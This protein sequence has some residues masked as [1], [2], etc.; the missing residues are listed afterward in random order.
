M[1]RRQRQKRR[2]QRNGGFRKGF[3]IALSVGIVAGFVG[4]LGLVGY[5]IGVAASAPSIDSLKPIDHGQTSVVYAADGKRLGFIT[6]DEL[7]TPVQ[8]TVIPNALKEATIAIEDQRFYHHKGVDYQAVIR[9]IHTDLRAGHYVQGAST[10]TQQL[11]RN[12]YTGSERTLGR[13]AKEALLAVQAERVY[14]KEEILARYLN[15]VYLGESTF[16]VEAASQSYFRKP[17]KELTLAEAAL[18]AGVIPAP[19]VYSP[20]ANPELA[21]KLQELEAKYAEHDKQLVVVFEAIG[22]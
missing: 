8:T 14:S 15:T 18:L 20:R 9:A 10:I 2:K 4:V 19:S 6:S 21:K 17:A 7:R 13:K 22:R 16:G 5:I 3:L 11:I 12:L 1:S